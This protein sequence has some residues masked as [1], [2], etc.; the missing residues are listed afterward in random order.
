MWQFESTPSSE[1]GGIAV[2][3]LHQQHRYLTAAL[4]RTNGT[5]TRVLAKLSAVE[6]DLSEKTLPRKEKRRLHQTRF[7]LNKSLQT[8]KNEESMLK[9]SIRDCVARIQAWQNAAAHQ[10][11]IH[12]ADFATMVSPCWVT[13]PYQ[14]F[15]AP[16]GYNT[17][18]HHNTGALNSAGHT[19][20]TPVG[21]SY[22]FSDTAPTVNANL[23][24]TLPMMLSQGPSSSFV[25]PSYCNVVD[26][27]YTYQ[28]QYPHLVGP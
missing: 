14:D 17:S 21:P 2:T 22:D 4:N 18:Y 24:P 12:H 1:F 6:K 10:L 25:Y 3:M 16:A 23:D 26:N 15:V 28:H 7:M 27:M 19:G 5:N 20:Q 13:S 9:E 8:C 11:N